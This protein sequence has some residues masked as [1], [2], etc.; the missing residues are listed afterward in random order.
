MNSSLI[1]LLLSCCCV[2]ARSPQNIDGLVWPTEPVTIH[3]PLAMSPILDGRDLRVDPNVFRDARQAETLAINGQL[4]AATQLTYWAVQRKPESYGYFQLATFFAFAGETNNAIH[5]LQKAA[6]FEGVDAQSVEQNVNFKS[7]ANDAR[8]PQLRTFFN[9]AQ[10]AWQ[11]S[12][13]HTES[14]VVPNG[15]RVGTPIPVLL[16]LHGQGGTPERMLSNGA[17]KGFETQTIA[18]KHKV[19]VLSISGTLPIAHY[20]F[21]WTNDLDRDYNHIMSALDHVKDRLTAD[22]SKLLVAGFSRG[23]QVGIEIAVRHP[24]Q[25]LGAFV[26][27]PGTGAGCRLQDI[28]PRPNLKNK[29]FYVLRGNDEG[30]A[31]LAVATQ[32]VQYVR[33]A[34]A[35]VI[36]QNIPGMAHRLPSNYDELVDSWAEVGFLPPE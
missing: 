10:S 33:A 9:A 13:H 34:G 7:V 17:M 14:L 36:L 22:S 3:D 1:L 11:S 31:S 16:M 4:K 25:F 6:F 20:S 12:R 2:L 15:Y 18:N 8:W 24:D 35:K 19:A 30:S 28:Y 23:A 32:D 26:A 5:W 21:G 27:C 29:R